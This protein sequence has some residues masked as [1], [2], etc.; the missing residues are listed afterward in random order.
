MY[1]RPKDCY[2]IHFG[3]LSKILTHYRV[4]LRDNAEREYVRRHTHLRYVYILY[5]ILCYIIYVIKIQIYWSD[6]EKNVKEM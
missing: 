6:V 2:Y 5:C 3:K 4:E 1:N